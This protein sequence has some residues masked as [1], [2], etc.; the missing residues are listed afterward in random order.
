M[1]THKSF[2][3]YLVL[4]FTDLNKTQIYKMPYG[5]SPHQEVE[6]LMSFDYLNLFKLNEHNEDY[7]IGKPNN[8]K[9][10]FE[11][12]D[13]KYVHLG[14]KLFRFQTDDEIVEHSSE[15]GFNDAKLPFAY[16]EE[17]I[18]FMLHQK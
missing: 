9:F 14:E 11:I 8:E 12:E 13:K 16:D 3:T 10:L 2:N 18:Y 7:L 5:N 15:H 17:N 1:L 4:I 6:I